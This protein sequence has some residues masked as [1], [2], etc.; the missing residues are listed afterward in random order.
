[1][2]VSKNEAADALDVIAHA[3]ARMLTL[4]RY[5]RLAP[6]LLTWGVIWIAANVITDLAPEWSNRAWIVGTVLGVVISMSLGIHLGRRARARPDSDDAQRTMQ[7][8]RLVLLGVA[9]FCYF[10]A[11][12]AVLGPLTTRQGNAFVS[13]FWAFAYMVIGA[14]VGWRLFAIGAVTAAAVL[15][16]YLAVEQHYYLWMAACG[17]G[18]LVAGGLWLRKI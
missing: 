13:L 5:A 9:F 16:G 15:F 1:M 8:R 18:A 4:G 10:P 7:T 3:K 17:G 14:W 2:N 11:T 12:F 6:F